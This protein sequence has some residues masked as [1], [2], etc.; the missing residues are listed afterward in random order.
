MEVIF[1]TTELHAENPDEIWNPQ[2]GGFLLSWRERGRTQLMARAWAQHLHGSNLD[3][4]M[5]L[6]DLLLESFLQLVLAVSRQHVVWI[7]SGKQTTHAKPRQSSPLKC[8]SRKSCRVAC[9]LEHNWL[10]ASWFFMSP[11]RALP[12]LSN[13]T[14]WYLRH[15]LLRFSWVELMLLCWLWSSFCISYIMKECHEGYSREISTL[16]H[17][18]AFWKLMLLKST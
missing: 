11:V 14:E 12:R 15:K 10:T 6:K 16:L 8:F 4:Q 1:H 18:G 9:V 3:T 5:N 7:L 17:C 13:S 2:N